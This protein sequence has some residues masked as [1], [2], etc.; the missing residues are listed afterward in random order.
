MA[1]C[2]YCGSTIFIGGKRDG[3]HRFCNASCQQ[4]G[5]VVIVA[6]QVPADIVR[7]EVASLHGGDCPKCKGE[8]PV[9]VHTSYRVW[10]AL[11]LTQWVS[12]PRIS[13]KSCGVKDKLGN[14]LFSLV[15]GWWGLPWGVLIT[16]LQVGRNLVGLFVWPDP[17]QPSEKLTQMVRMQLAANFIANQKIAEQ[18]A[19]RAAKAAAL[20]QKRF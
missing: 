15:L 16:P 1:S 4:K 7:K 13:C 5:A 9:D 3:E 17:S 19:R 14:A 2:T 12:L 8:G 20:E 11:V 6:G 18:E 10:S